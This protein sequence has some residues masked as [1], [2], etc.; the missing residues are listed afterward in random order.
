MIRL[1]DTGYQNTAAFLGSAIRVAEY[2]G[3]VPLEDA[4]RMAAQNNQKRMP[5]NPKADAEISYAR[6]EE[7]ALTSIARR[8][9]SCVRG[10]RDTS[11]FWRITNGSSAMPSMSLEL[12]V[13]GVSGAIAE[14][15]LLV[16]GSAIAEDAGLAQSRR[17]LSINNIGSFESS[18]RYVRDVAA[19]LRKHIESISPTLRPRAATDPLGT[20][21][22]L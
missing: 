21:V 14:A 8:A 7:R 13:V 2:Y 6:R 16:V 10:G 3:F 19:Y 4:M 17:M 1:R 12:H 15:L 9:A 20:L 5:A 22:Q 11:L 18:N